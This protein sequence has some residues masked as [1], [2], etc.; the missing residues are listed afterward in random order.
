[1][2]V[3]TSGR[4]WRGLALVSVIALVLLGALSCHKEV[5]VKGLAKGTRNVPFL[6]CATDD[7][8]HQRNIEITPAAGN[9][10]PPTV[11]VKACT[12]YPGEK[13][14]WICTDNS[15]C[16]GWK[17]I[18]DDL[19]V[20]DT[21]LFN[22]LENGTV[23]NGTVTFGDPMSAGGINHASGTFSPGPNVQP[24]LPGPFIVK[25]KVQIGQGLLDDPHI[26]PMSPAPSP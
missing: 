5:E 19:S 25:Y 22:N 13:I 2:K 24:L 26:V 10:N 17:V 4:Q 15:A 20:D 9:A 18:F 23:A 21:Q 7:T 16:P 3:C 12:I 1:M 11:S 14:K 8:G 6:E